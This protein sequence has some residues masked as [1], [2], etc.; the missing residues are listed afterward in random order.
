M[1]SDSSVYKSGALRKSKAHPKIIS[2]KFTEDIKLT[3]SRSFGQ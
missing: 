1:L 2:T 3:A